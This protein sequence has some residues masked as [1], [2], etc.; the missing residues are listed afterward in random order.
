MERDLQP[1]DRVTVV[2]LRLAAYFVYSYFA[3]AGEMLHSCFSLMFWKN[4]AA[5]GEMPH[6]R[7]GVPVM[8]VRGR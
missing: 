3:A 6:L 8:G 7:R 4:F 1:H 2:C 5:A